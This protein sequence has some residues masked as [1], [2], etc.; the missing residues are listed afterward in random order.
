MLITCRSRRTLSQGKVFPLH[1]MLLS[2]P[3]IIDLDP[4]QL[5]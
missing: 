5:Q 3:K 2:K 1:N 4:L